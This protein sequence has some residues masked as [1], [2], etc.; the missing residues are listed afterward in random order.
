MNNDDTSQAEGRSLDAQAG[1]DLIGEKQWGS[2]RRTKPACGDC[3]IGTESGRGT[4]VQSRVHMQ[5]REGRRREREREIEGVKSKQGKRERD[6]VGVQQRGE[7]DRD[8]ETKE[9]RK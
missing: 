6:R 5:R 7:L 9:L 2:G 3:R 4:S 1:G 8:E